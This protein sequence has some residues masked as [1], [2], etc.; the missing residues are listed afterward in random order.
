MFN[1]YLLGAL[2]FAAVSSPAF[3]QERPISLETDVF[4]VQQTENGVDLAEATS[5]VPGDILQLST[6]Y[7]N[8]T[9]QTVTNFVIKTPV[10]S[11]VLIAGE[12]LAE[13]EVSVDGGTVWGPVSALTITMEDGTERPANAGDVTHVRWILAELAPDQTGSV[14]YRATVK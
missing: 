10:P 9:G 1:R 7:A 13:L 3:A 8:N 4:L 11:N 6:K 2:A 14:S 5:V 12:S